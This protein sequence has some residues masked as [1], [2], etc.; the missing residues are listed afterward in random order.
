MSDVILCTTLPTTGQIQ[1]KIYLNITDYTL[2]AWNGTAWKQVG[3]NPQAITASSADTLTNKTI[4]ASANT[5]SNLDTVNFKSSAI[6]TAIPDTGSVNG[7]FATEKAVADYVQNKTSSL[8]SG[9]IYKGVFDASTSTL[10]ST[11]KQGDFYKISVAGTIGGVDLQV[12]DM[13]ISNTT[14]TTGV[15]ITDFDKIDNTEA[16]DILRTGNISINSDFTVDGTKITDRS[17][18]KIF[19]ESKTASTLTDSKSYTD[20]V[21]ATTLSSAKTYSDS[22]LVSAKTYTDNQITTALSWI[23]LT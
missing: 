14:K 18:I 10:P 21:A 23:D 17:T 4:D 3:G 6:S 11:V 8:A 1:G 13:L 7:K 19:V 20:S 22:N 12:G 5:I 15:V 16:Q 9:L 2:N